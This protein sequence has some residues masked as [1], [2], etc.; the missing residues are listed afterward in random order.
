MCC[1]CSE[2]RLEACSAGPRAGESFRPSLTV[3]SVAGVAPF[4]A[5][6]NQAPNSLSNAAGLAHHRPP[7]RRADLIWP[8]VSRWCVWRGFRLII[9]PIA[10]A[11]QTSLSKLLGIFPLTFSACSG[12]S[13][14]QRG[15]PSAGVANAVTSGVALDE[16]RLLRASQVTLWCPYLFGHNEH[17]RGHG[18]S[19]TYAPLS[20]SIR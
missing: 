9:S 20:A 3:T 8:L 18:V 1:V 12:L 11:P 5:T 16:T 2:V 13:I 14:M 19:D 10:T 6:T 7:I 17:S 15:S 4:G